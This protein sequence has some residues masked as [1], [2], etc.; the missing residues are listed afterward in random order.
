MKHF[1]DIKTI[2][3]SSFINLAA[4]AVSNIWILRMLGPAV[5]GIWKSAVLLVSLA[6]WANLGVT[7]GARLQ[8]PV[9]EAQH[10]TE[11][12][13]RLAGSAGAFSMLLGL[14]LGLGM[15]AASFFV[16]SHNFRIALRFVALSTA[17]MSP[18]CFLRD[19]ANARHLFDLRSKENYVRGVVDCIGGIIL[20][21]LFG[22]AGLGLGTALPIAV[23]VVFLWV[24]MRTV[25]T[26]SI[27]FGTVKKLIRAG[28]PY[29][30]S[31]AGFDLLRRL[32][33]IAVALLLGPIFVGY[34][35]IS[36]LTM[37]ICVLL[38]QRGVAEVLSPHM[39]RSLGQTDSF[40]TVA[41]FYESLARLTGYA[42]PPLLGVG[43]FILPICVRL[44]LPQYIPGIAPAQIT[45]FSVFFLVVH[46]TMSSFFV[47][48]QKLPAIFRLFSIIGLMGAA[49][50]FLV[51]RAGLGLTGV[52]W[53]TLATLAV[54]ISGE[55]VIARRAC[56]HNTAEIALYL[57]SLYFPVCASIGLM[58]LMNSINLAG[59]MPGFLESPV[60]AALYL[61]FYSPIFLIYESKFTMLRALYQTT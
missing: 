14:T 4:A 6:D 57:S 42:L 32:D 1:R 5:M 58:L 19:M 33:V 50:Q 2:S 13:E 10:N 47:A 43:A 52:A 51:L 39:Q 30:I 11:E 15:L 3:V 36:Y 34:Y 45:L 17:V 56:G 23:G 41:P 54:V 35:G 20:A 12:S 55:L 53:T 9:L 49:T 46:S 18:Y 28:L 61:L 37:D 59:W 44:A 60:K 7:R 26:F 48:A 38:S 21:K 8:I 40:A 16:G 27:D 29:Q 31:D 24:R 22:L 25:F